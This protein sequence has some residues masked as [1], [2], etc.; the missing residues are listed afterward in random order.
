ML[1]RFHTTIEKVSRLDNTDDGNPVFAI[2]TK[3]GEFQT[4]PGHQVAHSIH[5]EMA[6]RGAVVS[7]SDGEI[8]NLVIDPNWDTAEVDLILENDEEFHH[9][10]RFLELDELQVLITENAE[11]WGVKASNVDTQYIYN[12]IHSK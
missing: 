8:T 12:E 10:A 6:G 4:A 3:D 2:L 11:E 5:E 1:K 9:L 7:T